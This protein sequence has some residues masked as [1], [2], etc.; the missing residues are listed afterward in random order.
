MTLLSKYA[1]EGPRY[2]S[3]PTALTLAPIQDLVPWLD[4]VR[5][6]NLEP[7]EMSLYLH[8][9]FCKSLCWYCGCHKVISRNPQDS[10]DYLD[11]LEM[12]MALLRPMLNDNNRVVQLHLGGGTP[13]ALTIDQ[14][15]RLG[16]MLREHFPLAE[17]LEFSVEIDPRLF[18]LEQAQVMADIGV[19]RVSLG[20]QDIQTDV[21]E[22]IHRI[23]PSWMIDDS[24]RF[25]R[26]VGI[27]G[28]NMDLIYGLPHQ[29]RE[30]MR[31]TLQHVA[32]LRP[33]R[34]AIY[35]Y[36]HLPS[37][38]P[39]QKLIHS[40]WLPSSEEKLGIL[41]D[42]I[43]DLTAQGYDYIGMDHFALHD[44]AL[45]VALRNGTLQRN[46]QGYS[47]YGGA[48]VYG[49]G[50]SSISNVDGI[51]WQNHKDLDTYASSVRKGV[52]PWAKGYVLSQDD[53]IRRDVIMGIMCAGLV[54]WS[55]MK[56][57]YHYDVERM[58]IRE[59]LRLIPFIAD[60]LVEVTQGALRV[61]A[62]GRYYLRNIAMV[63]DAH[64]SAMQEVRFSKTL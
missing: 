52:H 30:S 26:E 27:T 36:A 55:D 47:T 43:G 23:Q 41:E 22:A 59:N 39:S 61:T 7:H 46:F 58:L 13:N 49:L 20:V 53:R 42:V 15:R 44:D 35:H 54:D 32:S 57:R 17:D 3:Y 6:V 34:F 11:A 16:A 5:K 18:T 28:I 33:S 62:D 56:Q 14:F 60:G 63:F 64:L 37:R 51:M 9:P 40:E 38:F 29:T 25:L 12:E 21:Q 48:H 4:T 1:T 2:T 45:A 8:I 24:V 10:D 50:I 19:N 31:K